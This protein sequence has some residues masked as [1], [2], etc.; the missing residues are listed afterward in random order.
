M[1]I[2]KSITVGLSMLI[3]ATGALISPSFA[4][5][6]SD[7]T[8]PPA[9][10]VT[11]QPPPSKPPT[12]EAKQ[13]S[14]RSGGK[15]EPGMSPQYTAVG[16][17]ILLD[18]YER[19]GGVGRACVYDSSITPYSWA[20]ASVTEIDQNAIPFQGAATI[21]VNNV[22]SYYGATC[23]RVEVLWDYPLPVRVDFQVANT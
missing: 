13:K 18:D 5:P 8:P 19:I 14:P 3:I 7:P 16:S 15:A 23:A 6:R 4:A 22:V 1:S 10:A 17:T 11:P 21:R 2:R 9:P 20:W 12:N